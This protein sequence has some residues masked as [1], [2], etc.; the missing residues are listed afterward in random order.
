MTSRLE[1]EIPFLRCTSSKEPRSTRKKMHKNKKFHVNL[2]ELLS[3]HEE[4]EIPN[5]ENVKKNAENLFKVLRLTLHQGFTHFTVLA[6]G[7][8]HPPGGGGGGGRGNT[9]KQKNRRAV[10]T[11][12]SRLFGLVACLFFY[13]SSFPHHVPF[14]LSS[15]FV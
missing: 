6:Q 14:Q 2:L 10:K 7:I 9:Y 3:Q 8:Y 1:T 13:T 11:L 5:L 15:T 12:K 4:A